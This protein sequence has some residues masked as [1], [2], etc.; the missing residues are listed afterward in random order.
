MDATEMLARHILTALQ[1]PEKDGMSQ[2]P[3]MIQRP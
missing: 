3:M 1:Y 2:L